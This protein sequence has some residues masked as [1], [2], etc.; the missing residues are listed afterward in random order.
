LEKNHYTLIIDIF[1]QDMLEFMKL[2]KM[3]AIGLLC[4]ALGGLK[5]APGDSEAEALAQSL[6]PAVFVVRE[7]PR[8][9]ARGVGETLVMIPSGA[10]WVYNNSPYTL[11][12]LAEAAGSAYG[13][14]PSTETLVNWFG[15]GNTES[16][17]GE[18]V[19]INSVGDSPSTS[20]AHSTEG[21]V[22]SLGP[23][24][25]PQARQILEENESDLADLM[26]RAASL[27]NSARFTQRA[28]RP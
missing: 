1:Y 12:T 6:N 13:A 21:S 19:L 8:A 20:S 25:T 2:S 9:L 10:Q 16:V 27:T 14:L 5:A 24:E 17:D 15:F 11:R 28:P 26:Q 3:F 22:A 18:R 7:A 23:E 4:H